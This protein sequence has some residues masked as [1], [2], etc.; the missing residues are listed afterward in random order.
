MKHLTMQEAATLTGKSVQAL[1]Q[2]AKRGKLHT[3]MI[4]GAYH[5]TVE[6]LLEYQVDKRFCDNLIVNGKRLFCE[7]QGFCSVK[8]AALMLNTTIN[9]VYRCLV[10]GIIKSERVGRYY[11]I[12]IS[13]IHRLNNKDEF[14]LYA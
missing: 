12:P 2:A 5:T 13:E 14:L 7:E 6:A 11:T 8:Q 9:K 10:Q 1:Y 4:G 3:V